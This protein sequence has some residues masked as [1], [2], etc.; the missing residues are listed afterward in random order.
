MLELP[1]PILRFFKKLNI[2]KRNKKPFELKVFTSM[3]YVSFGSVRKV[4]KFVSST[5]GKISKSSVHDCFRNFAEKVEFVREL[6]P[7]E[8]RIVAIDETVIKVNG[9]CWYVWLAVDVE[10]K[11]LVTFHVSRSRTD[12]E[13]RLFLLRLK[14]RCKGKLPLI[15]VDKGPWYRESL[16]RLG[17]EFK[18]ETFSKRN[19]VERVFGYLKQRGKIFKNNINAHREYEALLRFVKAFV[20]WYNEWR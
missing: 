15:L 8:Y 6:K 1:I 5:L 19:A 12:L 2:F 16:S 3:L 20:H 9:K 10:T 18:H 17:F 4:S 13:A 14:T 11:E 7:K